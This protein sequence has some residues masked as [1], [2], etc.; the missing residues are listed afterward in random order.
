GIIE[1]GNAPIVTK[2]VDGKETVIPP[3]SVEEKAQRK[4]ELKARRTLLMT[5]PNEHHLKFN[6]YKD[7]KILMQAIENRFGGY[8]IIPPPYNGSFMPPKP[9]LVYPSL[10]DFVDVNETVSECVIE[11]PSVKSTEPKTVRKQNEAPIIKDLVPKSEEEDEPKLQTLKPNFTKIEFVKPK[12]NRKPAEQIRQDTY[13]SPRET[14]ET[15]IS[16]CL[17]N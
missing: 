10:D 4:A 13:R 3:T 15:G 8:N 7:A 1:N 2:I 9:N 11:K 14:R 5:L 6:S 12:T 16:R 17:K